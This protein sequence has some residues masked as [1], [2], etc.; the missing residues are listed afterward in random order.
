[1]IFILILLL[2]F[3]FFL[4]I[5]LHIKKH[6][7]C[8]LVSILTDYLNDKMDI[9]IGENINSQIAMLLNNIQENQ[10]YLVQ[11]ALEEHDKLQSLI[12]DLSHQLKTPLTNL[13]MYQ[14]ILD[15][16]DLSVKEIQTFKEKIR[17][18]MAK[19]EWIVHSLINCMRLEENIITF[20]VEILPVKFTII[21]AIDSIQINADLKEIKLE[22]SLEFNQRIMVLHNFN[23]TR[24]VLINILDNAIKYSPVKSSINIHLET[25]EMYT[26]ICISDQGMGIRAEEINQ[27]FQRF[28]RSSD[29]KNT[30]GSG[31]GLYLSRLILEKEQAYITVESTLKKGSTF[32]IWLQNA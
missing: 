1:M 5:K 6:Q 13:K 27:I 14:S 20:S 26:V 28:Y 3:S 25:T 30:E 11:S 10:S 23:W 21:D 19:I 17:T 24:E 15:D 18:Q 32:K 22:L 4:L 16:D 2:F 8:E 31:I 29:T 9:K 7:E 12:S